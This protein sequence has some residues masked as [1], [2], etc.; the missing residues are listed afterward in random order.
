MSYPIPQTDSYVPGF[1]PFPAQPANGLYFSLY[2]DV[3]KLIAA[4]KK[5]QTTFGN[6]PGTVI[7]P[8]AN[9]TIL[10]YPSAAGT[11]VYGND[12]RRVW[13]FYWSESLVIDGERQQVDF[14]VVAGNLIYHRLDSPQGQWDKSVSAASGGT[15]RFA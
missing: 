8:T 11:F 13:C 5:E 3:Q 2:S 9:V 7:P 10:D 1:G 4:M 12:G 6:D 14:W 15:I